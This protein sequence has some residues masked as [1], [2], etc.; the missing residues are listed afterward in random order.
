MRKFVWWCLGG[1]EVGL[2]HGTTRKAKQE[3][4]VGHTVGREPDGET[5]NMG[6]DKRQN[7]ARI[8]CKVQGPVVG[9]QGSHVSQQADSKRVQL[10]RDHQESMWGVDIQ[11]R[12]GSGGAFLNNLLIDCQ[13]KGTLASCWSLAGELRSCVPSDQKFQGKCVHP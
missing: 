9:P 10:I 3:E 2:G 12:E 4:N 1:N 7:R 6:W 13:A 5:V 11:E 8:Q